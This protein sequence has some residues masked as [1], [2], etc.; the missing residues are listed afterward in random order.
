MRAYI[1]LLGRSVWALLNSYYA[2]LR[3]RDYRPDGVWIFTEE[4]FRS[5]VGTAEEGMRLISEAFGC[6][7]EISAEIVPDSD[8]VGV[9]RKISAMVKD[10]KAREYEVALDITPGRK[11]LVAGALLSTAGIHVDHVFYLLIDSLR[12]A[13]KPYPMIPFHLQHHNDFAEIGR[14]RS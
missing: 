1:T 11:A 3:E 5:R 9:G 7:P 8:F 12:D 10:L 6:G 14:S 2:A 4:A 13:S